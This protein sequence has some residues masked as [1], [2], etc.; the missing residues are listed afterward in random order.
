MCCLCSVNYICN[1]S[2]KCRQDRL[3]LFYC[4]NKSAGGL[5]V[6]VEL[7]VNMNKRSTAGRTTKSQQYP[8]TVVVYAEQL[9]LPE[10][11]ALL[12]TYTT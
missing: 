8:S 11:C 3:S 5:G 7:I 10:V 4:G 9:L 1:Q 2:H 6:S 12:Q